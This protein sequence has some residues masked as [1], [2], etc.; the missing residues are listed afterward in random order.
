VLYCVFKVYMRKFRT[1]SKLQRPSLTLLASTSYQHLTVF[2]WKFLYWL[3]TP[4]F[5]SVYLLVYH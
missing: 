5:L 1:Q 2:R 3:M 4:G